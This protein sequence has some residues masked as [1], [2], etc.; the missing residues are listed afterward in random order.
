MGRY[1]NVYSEEQKQ[2]IGHAIV[3]AGMHPREAA[4]AAKRGDLGL[5]PFE[6]SVS[7]ARTWGEQYRQDHPPDVAE[8]DTPDE[9]DGDEA[10]L[11]AVFE[12]HLAALEKQ[13]EEDP[14]NINLGQLKQAI[15]VQRELAK[16][17]NVKGWTPGGI[18]KD[19]R[20]GKSE[21]LSGLLDTLNG[22]EPNG[23]HRTHPPSAPTP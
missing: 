8:P 22:Q 7:A 13:V 17:R 16:L 3:V 4:D 5:D 14:L 20:R 21:Q 23:E 12:T 15:G 6:P 9:A 2:A 18:P 10:R 11:K 1:D 19:Q